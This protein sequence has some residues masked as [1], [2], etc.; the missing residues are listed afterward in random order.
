MFSEGLKIEGQLWKQR[1]A[2]TAW[3]V[4]DHCRS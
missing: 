3:R 2:E 4:A 1:G